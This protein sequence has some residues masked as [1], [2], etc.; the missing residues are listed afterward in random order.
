MT[1]CWQLVRLTAKSV[2]GTL[3]LRLQLVEFVRTI[4]TDMTDLAWVSVADRLSNSLS[5]TQSSNIFVIMRQH[6]T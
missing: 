5:L 4:S 1:V 3:L 6:Y 2:S